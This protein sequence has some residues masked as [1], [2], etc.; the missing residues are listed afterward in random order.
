MEKNGAFLKKLLA[1]FKVEAA[2]H[3]AAISSGL[4]E[5]E[6][7]PSAGRQAEIIEAVFR[8]SHSMKGAAR[9]VNL[10]VIE[11]V[12][13]HFEGV[14]SALKRKDIS[15]DRE[16]LDLLH[17][18]V[19]ALETLLSG[20]APPEKPGIVGLICDLDNA[21]RGIRPEERSEA[22]EGRPK[23]GQSSASDEALSLAESAPPARRAATET[24]RISK[25]RLDSILLQAEG[26]LSAKQLM[27]QRAADLREVIAEVAALKKEWVK[28]RPDMRRVAAAAEKSGS[29]QLKKLLVFL[30]AKGDGIS[31]LHDALSAIE[32][33]AG[34]DN[35]SIASMADSLLDEPQDRFDAP[36]FVS[37]RN[38]AEG[39][40][41]SRA[42]PG[43]GGDASGAGSRD[44]GRPSHP[45]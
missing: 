19:S 28:I 7:S 44:R 36:V 41:R 34:H 12:C 18:S 23:G 24:I 8:E 2:E 3:I 20:S 29:A 14:F 33:A 25:Q 37:A 1:T 30:D 17:R 21:A 10:T 11:N 40:P 16:L 42:R 35:R 4:I 9:A 5:L 27:S 26:L 22:T 39:R 45:G 32:K 13:Q 43:Q 31:K 15:P 6:K 38:D